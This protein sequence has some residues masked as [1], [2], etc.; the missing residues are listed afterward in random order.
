MFGDYTLH[1]PHIHPKF[2][3]FQ[4]PQ[5]WLIL[6]DLVDHHAGAIITSQV[7]ISTAPARVE[8]RRGDL[9]FFLGQDDYSP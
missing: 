8:E 5:L 3:G 2:S 6:G 1:G 4:D 9:A 7:S